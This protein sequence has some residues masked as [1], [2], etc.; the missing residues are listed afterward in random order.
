[1]LGRQRIEFSQA[2]ILVVDDTSTNRALLEEILN[3][4]G[5]KVATATSGAEALSMAPEIKPDLI[6]LDV[7]MPGMDGF[8]TCDRLKQ[9]NEARDIPVV[10]VTART[11]PE[12]IV[13]GFNVGA[14]DYITKPIGEREVCARVRAHI[15][16]RLL[17][18]QR[19]EMAFMAQDH[20][21]R[22]NFVVNDVSDAVISVCPPGRVESANSSALHLFGYTLKEIIGTP[23]TELML[24]NYAEACDQFFENQKENSA[25]KP[26]KATTV[27]EIT[28]R[29]SDGSAVPID[30]SIRRLDLPYPLYVCLMHDLS[31]HKKIIDEMQRVSNLDRLTNMPN[32]KRFEEVFARQWERAA[33]SSQSL[34]LLM[35]QIDDFTAY[36]RANGEQAADHCIQ[37]VAGAINRSVTRPNDLAA[38]FEDDTFVVMLADTDTVGAAA[39]AE[40]I[41]DRVDQL[42][43]VHN[44]SKPG[45][46]VHINTGLSSSVVQSGDDPELMLVAVE[47]NLSE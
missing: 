37:E 21:A 30:F 3:H 17:V 19:N 27:V 45:Q 6:L 15:S 16:N 5:Y 12:D 33:E 23:L 9:L 18:R 22:S 2:E 39:V 20:D 14:I 29:R 41:S 40:N 31:P 38:R 32:R 35:I 13:K 28:G 8:E 36:V 11:N 7:M 10:F 4:E 42:A 44:G 26:G 34:S 24:P 25:L 1:M 46:M 47:K 43:L